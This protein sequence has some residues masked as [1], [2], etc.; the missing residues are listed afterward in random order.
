MFFRSHQS[1]LQLDDE[2]LPQA[3]LTS[4]QNSITS[5]R[6]GALLFYRHILLLLLF[7]MS[8]SKLIDF[9]VQN[10]FVCF[11]A[12]FFFLFCSSVI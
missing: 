3:Y 12:G 8:E 11:G 7:F 5:R 10:W 2:I 4:Y 6:L 9:C 1:L